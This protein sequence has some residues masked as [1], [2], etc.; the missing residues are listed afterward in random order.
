[1]TKTQIKALALNASRQLNAVAKDVYNLEA[2]F[3]IA[4]TGYAVALIILPSL[5]DAP[6]TEFKPF[7]FCD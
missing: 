1:M 5:C 3:K 6:H 4:Q 7:D 2:F